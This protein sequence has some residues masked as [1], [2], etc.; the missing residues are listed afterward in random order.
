MLLVAQDFLA[1]RDDLDF[2]AAA[3]FVPEVAAL[4]TRL[5]FVPALGPVAEA[6]LTALRTLP[7]E[8]VHSTIYELLVGTASRIATG[9]Q[10]RTTCG[11]SIVTLPSRNL[12]TTRS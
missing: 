9:Q 12:W 11:R 6:K 1:G 10:Q 7:E 8:E 4:G 3:E 2:Y 5:G